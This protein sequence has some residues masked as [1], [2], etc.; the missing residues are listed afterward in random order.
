MIALR[1]G[2]PMLSAFDAT[3][4]LETAMVLFNA[5]HLERV[6]R[7][8]LERH[9]QVTRGP[10]FNAAVWGSHLEDFD[11]AVP[12]EMNDQ[13]V[14]RNPYL[15]NGAIAG[16]LQVHQA[17]RFQLRQPMPLQGPHE[18]QVLQAGIP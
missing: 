10:V 15:S 2:R 14:T 7:A 17:V 4:L 13:A 11:Q 8:L 12:F 3:E 18:F 1:C 16:T 9:G 5:P 6:V